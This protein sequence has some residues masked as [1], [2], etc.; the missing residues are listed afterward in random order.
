MP[1]SG[2]DNARA[3]GYTLLELVVSIIVVT[4]LLGVFL[5]RTLY[6]RELAEKSAMEQVAYDLRSSVNLRAAE[7]VLLN[8]FE[9]LAGLATENPID[10]LARKPVNYL[11][12]LTNPDREALADGGWYFDSSTKEV[13]YCVV[14]KRFFVPGA[15]GSTC[16]SWRVSVA[17]IDGQSGKPAWAR[18]ELVGGY[19]WF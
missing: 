2:P 13:V 9:D 19:R 6:Y 14:S 8:K 17:R 4:V 5:D 10:L 1:R 11:G 16:V 7:L 18:F 12:V 15:P 3:A